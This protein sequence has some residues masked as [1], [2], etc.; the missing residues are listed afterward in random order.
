LSEA[1]NPAELI[2]SHVDCHSVLAATTIHYVEA[3]R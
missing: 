2:Q 1:P 3:L